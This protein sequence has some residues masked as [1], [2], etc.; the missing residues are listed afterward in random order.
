MSMFLPTRVEIGN[1]VRY[2]QF[3]KDPFLT[4][5]TVLNKTNGGIQEWAGGLSMVYC[6]VKNNERWAFKAWHTEIR[7]IRERY[8]K[9]SA[10][11]RRFNLSY[12]SEFQ[13]VENGL[14]VTDQKLNTTQLIDTLRM[15]WISGNT[16]TEYINVNL[17]NKIVL[18]NL[19]KRFLRMVKDL[20]R[21][22]ISHGDLKNENIFVTNE[23]KIKLID[24]DSLCVPGIEGERDICRGT[25]GFQ[26]PS[27]ITS[28]L[29][30]SLKIDYFSEL[31]IYI[32]ILAVAESP[33]LWERYD[34]VN[35]DYR[36]LFKQEDFIQWEDSRIKN[37]LNLLSPRI[38][39]LLGILESY[40]ASHLLLSP[41]NNYNSR[42]NKFLRWAKFSA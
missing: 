32:S 39:N 16:L 23:G 4:G 15:K 2:P 17:E 25:S 42:T 24:Y 26:H 12:F 14:L 6:L 33:L 11:L 9:I 13:F 30:A 36:L 10:H 20:R 29:T 1:A 41:F 28:G 38:Q 18:E 22:S 7:D 31:I 8:K 27:R 37:D 21:N 19:A 35:A 34:V 40:L 3:I 5:Y